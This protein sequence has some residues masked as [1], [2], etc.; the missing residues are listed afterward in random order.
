MALGDD[1]LFFS[2]FFS[3]SHLALHSVGVVF[4]QFPDE[5]NPQQRPTDTREA[6]GLELDCRDSRNDV[7]TEEQRISAELAWIGGCDGGRGVE[8]VDMIVLSATNLRLY[9]RHFIPECDVPTM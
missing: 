3:L 2:F 5:G 8:W 6:C 4:V 1:L 7:S 9:G